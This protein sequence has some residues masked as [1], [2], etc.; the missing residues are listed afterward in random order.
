MLY[1]CN[2]NFSQQFSII[3]L[4]IIDYNLFIIDYRK[5][6]NDSGLG[7]GRFMAYF[8]IEGIFFLKGNLDKGNS[9]K[10]K[11]PFSLLQNRK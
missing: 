6:S 4:K 10:G 3:Q 1:L 9:Y 11:T 8:S 5:N 2:S 7:E